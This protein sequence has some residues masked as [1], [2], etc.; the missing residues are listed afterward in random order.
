MN[1]MIAASFMSPPPIPLASSEHRK[2]DK[3]IKNP[4]AA[5]ITEE[6]LCKNQMG[7]PVKGQACT[8]GAGSAA[9][10]KKAR[11]LSG[12]RRFSKSYAANP[13]MPQRMKVS[14][15]DITV[16]F[17]IRIPVIEYTLMDGYIVIQIDRQHAIR[18]P[19]IPYLSVY[20]EAGIIWKPYGGEMNIPVIG[21]V[22]VWLKGKFCTASAGNALQ[23]P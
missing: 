21:G 22:F 13:A 8:K 18:C 7:H 17:T 9:R 20:H 11:A 23:K 1:P 14:Y 6:R 15:K 4:I 12:T 5:P 19:C 10:Q 2:A 16:L 3:R